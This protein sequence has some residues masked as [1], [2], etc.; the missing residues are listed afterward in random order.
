MIQT[1]RILLICITFSTGIQSIH[2]QESAKIEILHSDKLL[3]TKRDGK[4]IRR[5]VGNVELLHDSV[6]MFCDS[7]YHFLTENYFTAYSNV[8]VIQGD[9]LFLYGDSLKY[10]GNSS[11]GKV[12]GRVKLLDNNMQLTTNFLDFNTET[13][14]SHYFNGGTIVDSANTLF[15]NSGYYLSDIDEFRFRDSVVLVNLDYNIFTD[16]LHYSTDTEKSFFFGPTDIVTDSSYIYCENGWYDTHFGVARFGKN[17]WMQRNEIILEA[18][19]LNYNNK[20][21]LGIARKNVIIEDT[22]QKIWI[23]GQYAYLN[24]KKDYSFVTD[25]ALFI[26]FQDNDSL[27]LHADTLFSTTDSLDKKLIKAYRGVKFYRYEMQ[28]KCDSLVYAESDSLIKLY[29]SPILWN[30]NNQITAEYIQIHNTDGQADRVDIQQSAFI[31]TKQD[32]VKYNQISGKNMTGYI[33]ENEIRKIDV[34]GNAQTIYFP[35]DGED[36]I[37]INM[38]E[39]SNMTIFLR[40]AEVKRIVWHKLPEGIMKPLRQTNSEELY[41]KGFKWLENE[42]PMNKYDIFTE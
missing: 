16:T 11:D 3:G 9:S 25:S 24:Q 31:V 30:E 15:S 6:H 42:R 20:T 26:L 5:L 13:N 28:G 18:D 34:D 32:S 39:S 29:H 12:R 21:G 10:D 7:A 35:K 38:A 8:R 14:V 41:L 2:S 36:I 22:I 19:S 17:T 4:T 37:G 33:R 27:Y 23:K 40:D 1:L